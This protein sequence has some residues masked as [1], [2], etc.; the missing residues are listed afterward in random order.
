MS[1][2]KISPNIDCFGTIDK[3]NKEGCNHCANSNLCESFKPKLE[4]HI[5]EAE[6]R[7]RMN[8]VNKRSEE[9]GQTKSKYIVYS[10]VVV[11]VLF[12]FLVLY[13]E[14]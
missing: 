1:E 6:Q 8:Y 10:F 3:K 14:V 7:G 13:Q 11:V 4:Q 5:A 12:L 9:V 2:Q